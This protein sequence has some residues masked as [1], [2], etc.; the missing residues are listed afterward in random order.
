MRSR[1]SPYSGVGRV[2]PAMPTAKTAAAARYPGCR[3]P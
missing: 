2:M 1:Y 3:R